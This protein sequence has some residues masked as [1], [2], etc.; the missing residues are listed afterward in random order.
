MPLNSKSGGAIAPLAPPSWLLLNSIPSPICFI[1][2]NKS[3]MS[4]ENNMGDELQLCATPYSILN[5]CDFS[6]LKIYCTFRRLIYSIHF[7][8]YT[9]HP[10]LYTHVTQF[11]PQTILP[12]RIIGFLYTV[13]LKRMHTFFIF[14]QSALHRFI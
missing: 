2:F 5:V 13:Y 9:P 7:L 14:F 8:D 4:T 1:S 12:H 11:T 6:S 10:P 3:L